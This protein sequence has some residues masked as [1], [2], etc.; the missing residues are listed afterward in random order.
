MDSSDAVILVTG[1]SSGI[2]AATA[3]GRDRT[4]SL[5]GYGGAPRLWRSRDGAGWPRAASLG[6][7]VP[8]G[9]GA[10]RI[11]ARRSHG[12]VR[13]GVSAAGKMMSTVS[14]NHPQN[15]IGPGRKR[16]WR[17]AV[18]SGCG[19]RNTR[20]LRLVERT[21]P[22]VG[23]V[24]RRL[25]PEDAGRTFGCRPGASTPQLVTDYGRDRDRRRR[26]QVL[27]FVGFTG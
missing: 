5:G 11:G 22:S 6:R 24:G 14:Q 20:F 1:A 9:P 27:S 8:A 25:S 4:G 13:R 7:L 18:Q 26:I 12:G 17:S 3:R 10:C 23:G 16:S 21:I 2:G 19:A 15:L